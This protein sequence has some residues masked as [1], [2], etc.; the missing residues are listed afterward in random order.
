MTH[1]SNFIVPSPFAML[2][3]AVALAAGAP[4]FAETPTHP[5]TAEQAAQKPIDR[6]EDRLREMHAKLKIT[7]EQD[8][9][10]E[11]FVKAERDSAKDM[12]DLIAKRESSVKTMNAID[13]FKNYAAITEAHEEGL[14]KIIPAFEKLYGSLSDEQKKIADDMFKGVGEGK[15]AS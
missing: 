3:A 2:I 12:S 10:W 7:A 6:T 1:R 8:P 9:Q 14:K 4:A 15:R 13:D 11:N 5:T